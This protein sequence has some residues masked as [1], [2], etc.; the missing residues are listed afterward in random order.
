LPNL[1]GVEIKTSLLL[2]SHPY[3]FMIAGRSVSHDPR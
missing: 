1:R 2:V 3:F